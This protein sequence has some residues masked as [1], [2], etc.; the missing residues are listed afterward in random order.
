MHET[1]ALSFANLLLELPAISI[2]LMVSLLVIGASIV[3][4]AL[5][6]GYGLLAAPFL[7]LIEPAYVPGPTI[8]IGMIS[9]SLGAWSERQHIIWPE[10][11]FAS[12]GRLSGVI[13]AVILLAFIATTGQFR[14][15][16]GLLVGLAVMLTVCGWKMRHNKFSLL[17]MG[18][19]SGCMGTITGVGA[20]PL[21][22]IY[23]DRPAVQAR[24]TLAA[25]FCIGC[26]LSVGGLAI[27]GWLGGR[28]VALAISLLP[29]MAIGTWLGRKWSG[30]SNQRY[31]Q[32][33]LA[34]AGIASIVL[35]AQGVYQLMLS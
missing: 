35:I 34:L 2:M 21:A 18:W 29:A 25:F 33:L 10:V 9:S 17:G 4:A 15:V 16:F 24:P 30:Q 12:L 28:E 5:G 6:M 31:R 3:Q 27:S 23:H 14:L 22:L 7:M 19:M 20:P 1:N 26:A 11:A 32:A 8:L 13:V